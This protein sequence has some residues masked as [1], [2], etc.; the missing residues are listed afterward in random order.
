MRTQ[1]KKRSTAAVTRQNP[2][3]KS[4]NRS[5]DAANLGDEDDET[6]RNLTPNLL[7]VLMFLLLEARIV[8]AS[9]D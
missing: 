6:W 8:N 9:T 3:H 5:Q 1:E 4:Q 7:L 2:N